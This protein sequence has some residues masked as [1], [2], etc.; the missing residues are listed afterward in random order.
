[1]I[2]DIMRIFLESE[3]PAAAKLLLNILRR[4]NIEQI[5]YLQAEVN[6][7]DAMYERLE[8]VEMAAEAAKTEHLDS[9]PIAPRLR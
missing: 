6:E 9:N 3:P 1:M 7:Y 4:K 5:D 2:S 8:D